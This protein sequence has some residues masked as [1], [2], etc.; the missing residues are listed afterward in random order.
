MLV[1]NTCLYVWVQAKR[2]EQALVSK[3]GLDRRGVGGSAL[4]TAYRQRSLR[5]RSS[6]RLV[7]DTA[8]PPRRGR[9][10]PTRTWSS[11]EAITFPSDSQVNFVKNNCTCSKTM[12]WQQQLDTGNNLLPFLLFSHIW[13]SCKSLLVR[14]PFEFACLMPK[15]SLCCWEQWFNQ[16]SLPLHKILIYFVTVPGSDHISVTK[17]TQVFI[18]TLNRN[19]VSSGL[20]RAGRHSGTWNRGSRG[21]DRW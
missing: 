12:Q 17:E 19:I 2:L 15:V 9:N 8:A 11:I 18:N 14:V 1:T 3:H 21:T 5:G 10:A 16:G 7:G 20:W 6:L 13:R 4:P